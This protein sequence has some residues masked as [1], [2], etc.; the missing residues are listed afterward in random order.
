LDDIHTT[1]GSK[2]LIKTF[3]RWTRPVLS[4]PRPVKRG[5]VLVVDVALCVLAVW[6]AFYLRLGD[7]VS[8]QGPVLLAVGVSLVLALPIFVVLGL[9]R[10]IFR[11]SNLRAM[12]TVVQAVALYGILYAF[13]FTGIAFE[14]VPRTLGLIQPVLLLS[15]VGASRAFAGFWFGRTYQ[16]L[17]KRSAL[18]QVLVYGAG[19]AG[20]QLAANPAPT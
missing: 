15:L 10:A 9:Y 2:T 12:A 1:T 17:I 19:S 6:L 7:F 3:A 5:V 11:Y 8:L 20:R 14:G 13:V 4:L 16:S 18:P